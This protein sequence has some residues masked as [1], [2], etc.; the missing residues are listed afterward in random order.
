MLL[1]LNE[2]K[3][4][5]HV[6]YQY[7]GL[8]NFIEALEKDR[9]AKKDT[10]KTQSWIFARHS[11]RRL[12]TYQSLYS[13]PMVYPIRTANRNENSWDILEIVSG[14]PDNPAF[15]PLAHNVDI[16]PLQ[17]NWCKKYCDV[18]GYTLIKVANIQEFKKLARNFEEEKLQR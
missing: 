11:H 16:E 1:L 10:R 7:R 15:I 17:Q 4:N 14:N 18:H 13:N 3:N 6:F 5:L 12:M 8:C 9:I 2:R